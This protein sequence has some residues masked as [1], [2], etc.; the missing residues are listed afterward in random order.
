MDRSVECDDRAGRLHWALN[1]GWIAGKAS[2][3]HSIFMDVDITIGSVLQTA[4]VDC[5]MCIV[6]RLFGGVGI[7]MLSIAASLY[8]SEIFPVCIL[9]HSC[10]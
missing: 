10:M 9:E 5:L 7:G 4:A 2:R 3:K 1:Q 8:I 6:A